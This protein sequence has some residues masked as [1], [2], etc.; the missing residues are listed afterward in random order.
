[1]ENKF[2]CLLR[3]LSKIN[4]DFIYLFFFVCNLA[5]APAFGG[6]Y[7]KCNDINVIE[8]FASNDYVLEK[9]KEGRIVTNGKTTNEIQQV[10]SQYINYI[11]FPY[12]ANNIDYLFQPLRISKAKETIEGALK[13]EIF[14]VILRV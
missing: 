9:S 10:N 12:N 11:N 8:S 1:M 4:R 7:I 5:V 6:E 3:Y 2:L 13:W 14:C